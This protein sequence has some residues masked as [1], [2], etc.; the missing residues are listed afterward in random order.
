M[1][2]SC[3][4]VVYPEGHYAAIAS[5]PR[6][7]DTCAAQSICTPAEITTTARFRFCLVDVEKLWSKNALQKSTDILDQKN[8]ATQLPFAVELRLLLAIFGQANCKIF[9]LTQRAMGTP[10]PPNLARR[11]SLMSV[12]SWLCHSWTHGMLCHTTVRLSSS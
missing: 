11:T 1:T 4:P 10:T 5:L 6:D 2:P 12:D 7:C 9:P 3:F 8:E